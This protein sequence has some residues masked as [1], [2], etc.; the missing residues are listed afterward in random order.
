M[1]ASVIAGI[2]DVVLE[3]GWFNQ[4]VWQD[5]APDG[6]T[7]PYVVIHDG[8]DMTPTLKGDS[9]TVKLER[10]VQV[11]VFFNGAREDKSV[12]TQ[13]FNALDGARIVLDNGA[14]VLCTAQGMPRIYDDS[15]NIVHRPLTLSAKHDP[16][17]F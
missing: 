9:D 7:M 1:A 13:V 8:I 11:S 2:S 17:A 5:K 4:R 16:T 15:T 14:K 12:A 10:L 6:A 3:G